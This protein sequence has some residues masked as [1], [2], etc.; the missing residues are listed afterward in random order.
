MSRSASG[1]K[2][3]RRIKQIRNPSEAMQESEEMVRKFHGREPRQV[4]EYLEEEKYEK[5]LGVLGQLLELNILKDSGKSFIPIRFCKIAGDGKPALKLD[6][7]VQVCCDGKGEQIYFKSGEQFLDLEA[8]QKHGLGEEKLRGKGL[9]VIGPVM[10]IVYWADK[11][12]LE[13]PKYQAK[14]ASYEH[15]FGEEADKGEYGEMPVL[16][17]DAENER[18]HLSGGS[19]EIRTEGIWN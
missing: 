1:P 7:M 16:V 11:H 9:I 2:T 10:S 5:D 3:G 15:H 6:D 18:M 19:Y 8:L 14:G 13:G 4:L 12:H 17:Y